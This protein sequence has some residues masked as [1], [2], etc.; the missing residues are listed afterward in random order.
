MRIS[1]FDQRIHHSSNTHRKSV[2][3]EDS[4]EIDKMNFDELLPLVLP[5]LVKI[6]VSLQSIKILKDF[7]NRIPFY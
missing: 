5:F 7:D 4:P 1:H 3:N 6:T 2:N